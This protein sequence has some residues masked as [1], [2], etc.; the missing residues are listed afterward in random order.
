[1]EVQHERETSTFHTLP[2]F[3]DV[4]QIL[5]RITTGHGIDEQT[6]ANVVDA[7]F[8][9]IREDVW[10]RF[11]GLIKEDRFGVFIGWK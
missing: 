2:S 4:R 10:D 8:F 1:V 9:E 7:F 11:P 3:D 5:T 6:R